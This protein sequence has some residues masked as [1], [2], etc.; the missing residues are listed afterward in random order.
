MLFNVCPVPTSVLCRIIT[1]AR[2]IKAAPCCLHRPGLATHK[3]GQRVP[4]AGPDP[5]D[6]KMG[7]G[8]K[9]GGGFGGAMRARD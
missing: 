1:N 2:I 9:V 6:S 3:K 5:R 7:M 4:N 8:Q